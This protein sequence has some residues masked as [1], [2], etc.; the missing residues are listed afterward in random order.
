MENA[1]D[2]KH[3]QIKLEAEKARLESELSE[4]GRQNPHIK[5]DWE[6]SAPNMDTLP[7]DKNEVADKIEEF[8]Q[9]GLILDELE[10][11]YNEVLNALNRIQN[12]TYGTCNICN[13]TIPPKRLEAYPA[14]HSCIKHAP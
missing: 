10:T 11:E 8:E 2:I 4:V 7:S 6:V 1:L 12:N 5:G 3:F 9:R 13:E 14:A